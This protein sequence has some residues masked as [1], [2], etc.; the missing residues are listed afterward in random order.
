[1]GYQ[2]PHRTIDEYVK[3]FTGFRPTD[4]KDLTDNEPELPPDSDLENRV[5]KLNFEKMGES[6]RFL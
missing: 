4:G 6:S 3:A 2:C 5:S 1:V